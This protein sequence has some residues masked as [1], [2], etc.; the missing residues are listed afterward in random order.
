MEQRAETVVVVGAGD[1]IGAAICKAFAAEGFTVIAG[2]RNG[3]KLQPLVDEVTAAGGRMIGK[4]L[5][6]RDEDQVIDF[7]K[8]AEEVGPIEVCIFNV[9]ANVNFP[10]TETTERVFRKVWE[11]AC[12]AGFLTGREAAKA[13]LPRGTGNIF[14]TG[15]TAGLRGNPGF[16]AFASAKFGIRA[17]AEC[18]ARELMPKGIHVAHLVIDSGVDTQWVREMIT[19]RGGNPEDRVLMDPA[20]VAKT[21]IQLWKQPKDAWMFETQIRPSVETW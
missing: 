10:F 1:F 17:V 3:D 7:I 6:A 19:A 13:M 21:Y 8:S 4:S 12:Y 18:A 11:M 5:D 14:F 2:R 16:A 9:G 20:S 15:A